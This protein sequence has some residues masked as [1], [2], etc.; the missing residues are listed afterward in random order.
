M[1]PRLSIKSSVILLCASALL[2]A[3]CA[4][5]SG[6]GLPPETRDNIHAL[7]D[8]HASI[9]RTVK[10]T[11]EGYIARTESDDPNVAR[12]LKQHIAQMQER[13]DSGLSVRRWDPAFADYVRHYADI[14]HRLTPI[15]KGV[16][17]EVRGRTTA[18]IRAAQNH[19][20]VISAFV[21][22]GWAEHG[23]R[24]PAAGN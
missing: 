23:K 16:Q 12:T 6:H 11:G 24:H 14:E 7:F 2:P 3:A 22:Q 8:N 17:M 15:E 5:R 9:A 13:L 1:K 4:Q 19:A 20:R 18:A 21:A 10:L